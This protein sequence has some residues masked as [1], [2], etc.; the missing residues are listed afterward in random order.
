VLTIDL[1]DTTIQEE[2]SLIKG[3]AIKRPQIGAV[4]SNRFLTLWVISLSAYR[5]TYL[6]LFLQWPTYSISKK[7]DSLC[8]NKGSYA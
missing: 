8:F 1:Y 6:S 7:R 2:E 5:F 4:F 3:T